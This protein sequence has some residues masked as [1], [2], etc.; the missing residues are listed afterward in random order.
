MAT[1]TAAT[2][3]PTGNLITSAWMTNVTGMI[4]FLGAS[5]TS[6]KDFAYLRQTTAQSMTA[7]S[8]GTAN[9]INWDTE[10]FDAANGHGTA[11]TVYMGYTAQAS[12]KY[13][14]QACI[15]MA[16]GGASTDTISIRFFK[17]S[18]GTANTEI[19]GG[20][21]TFNNVST[22]SIS[23]YTTPVF[24]TSVTAG[25]VIDVRVVPTTTTSTNAG[26]LISPSWSI[27]WVGA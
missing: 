26:T 1:W 22:S 24:F 4:N 6:A 20:R 12:G 11:T 9:R 5:G 15:P 7:L 25:D 10:D 21:F 18:G 3:I 2:A 17:G 13:A 23:A 14:L 8:A 16:A 27:Q 19:T